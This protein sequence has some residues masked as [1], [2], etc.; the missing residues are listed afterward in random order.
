MTDENVGTD[1][2]KMHKGSPEDDPVRLDKNDC[3]IEVNTNSKLIVGVNK[4]LADNPEHAKVVTYAFAIA[5]LLIQGTKHGLKEKTIFFNKIFTVCKYLCIRLCKIIPDAIVRK[6]QKAKD[7]YD[8]EGGKESSLRGS[9]RRNPPSFH[10]ECNVC[11]TTLGFSGELFKTRTQH[12][13]NLFAG[14]AAG[15]LIKRFP[16]LKALL[17]QKFGKDVVHLHGDNSLVDAFWETWLECED[18]TPP[19]D[20]K[21]PKKGESL[22]KHTAKN[23]RKRLKDDGIVEN[24]TKNFTPSDD[25]KIITINH[26]RNQNVPGKNASAKESWMTVAKM[27]GYERDEWEEL[28]QEIK[29]YCIENKIDFDKIEKP[30]EKANYDNDRKH[31]HDDDDNDSKSAI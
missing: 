24:K 23:M 9:H 14:N 22:T 8:N 29:N 19:R 15:P 7:R 1:W 27:M 17:I 26:F 4:L 18:Y 28:R 5:Y 30:K 20:K 21:H 16:K 13:K 12:W 25:A 2:I 3:K 11:N 10:F 31:N 6:Q